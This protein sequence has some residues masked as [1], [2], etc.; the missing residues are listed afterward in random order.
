MDFLVCV[1]LPES[2]KKK[3]MNNRNYKENKKENYQ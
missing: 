2:L 3:D 1:F